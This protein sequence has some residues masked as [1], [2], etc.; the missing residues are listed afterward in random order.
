MYIFYCT[1]AVINLHFSFCLLYIRDVADPPCIRT[2]T[3]YNPHS[4]IQYI[5]EKETAAVAA[6]NERGV[7]VKEQQKST[8]STIIITT[9]CKRTRE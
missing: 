8:E 6:L 7:E 4:H 9:M 1:L 3:I 5:R 2:Y